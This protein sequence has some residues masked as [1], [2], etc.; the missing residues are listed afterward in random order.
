MPLEFFTNQMNY[1]AASRS[2]VVAAICNGRLI[3]VV[4]PRAVLE[5]IGGQMPLSQDESIATVKGNIETLR[6]AA[7]I[8]AAR[9]GMHVAVT[10]IELGD[11]AL[12]SILDAPTFAS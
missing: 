12:T 5:H 1:R 4:V 3:D 10:V 9:D 7:G 6:Q 2:V 8:S 11:V